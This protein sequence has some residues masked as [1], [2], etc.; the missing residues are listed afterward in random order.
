MMQSYHILKDR[1]TGLI[2]GES[3]PITLGRCP[4]MMQS[5]HI[6]DDRSYTGSVLNRSS[7]MIQ[8]CHIL[9]DRSHHITSGHMSQDDTIPLHSQR[10]RSSDHFRASSQ[11]WYNPTTFSTTEVTRL[12][13]GESVP[14]TLG[15]SPRTMQSYHILKDRRHQIDYRENQ[16][17]SL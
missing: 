5:Y 11:G 4:R 2:T 6:L 14:I 7:R 12:I 10:L 13:T 17:L 15:L 3:V 16:S 9:D 1:A 8:S